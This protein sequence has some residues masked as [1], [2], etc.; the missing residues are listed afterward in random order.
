MKVIIKR[1]KAPSD[2]G[3]FGEL[4]IEGLPDKFVTLELPYKD[5]AIGRSSIPAGKYRCIENTESKG[6]FRLLNVKGRENILIHT[7]NF[8]GDTSKGYASDV[9]GC[10]LIGMARGELQNGRGR[11][12]SAVL[13]SR[14][15]MSE[16]KK[17]VITP[18]ELD[19]R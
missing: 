12:Q 3:I 14:V 6:G 13:K 15:G 8:A 4:T 2:S 5:N 18:F 17:L 1:D 7:G 19:I 16:F 10:I 9:E 11:M